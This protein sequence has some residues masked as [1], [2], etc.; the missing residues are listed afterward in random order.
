MGNYEGQFVREGRLAPRG[1]TCPAA[2][3][4]KEEVAKRLPSF[5]RRE[6]SVTES[7]TLVASLKP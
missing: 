1:A 7:T 2:L 4:R 3:A 5:H 6:R